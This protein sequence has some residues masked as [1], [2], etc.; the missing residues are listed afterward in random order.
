MS[1][2]KRILEIMGYQVGKTISEQKKIILETYLRKFTNEMADLLINLSSETN[3]IVQ[4]LI[5]RGESLQSLSSFKNLKDKLNS[6]S[7]T[8]GKNFDEQIDIL[9]REIDNAGVGVGKLTDN[10]A[11]V[12]DD[13]LNDSWVNIIRYI[14]NLDNIKDRLNWWSKMGNLD[15][16]DAIRIIRQIDSPGFDA[17]SLTL[18]ELKQL[19]AN[20][21]NLTNIFNSFNVTYPYGKFKTDIVDE[22]KR[23]REKLN[24]GS[25]KENS[26]QSILSRIIPT[27]G[28]ANLIYNLNKWILTYKYEKNP[29]ALSERIQKLSNKITEEI[30][31]V[32][33]EGT[34]DVLMNEFDELTQL[35]FTFKREVG[36]DMEAQLKKLVEEGVVSK[37]IL[38][39][40]EQ[41]KAKGY[42]NLWSVWNKEWDEMMKN[43]EVR[44]TVESFGGRAFED[45]WKAFKEVLS[46]NP[47]TIWGTLIFKSGRENFAKNFKT[48]LQRTGWV[49]LWNDPR[50]PKELVTLRN[51]KGTELK[52]MI[53]GKL[54]SH[55]CFRIV[56]ILS[57]MPV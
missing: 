50:F 42:D 17:K 38:G 21:D 34:I 31:K 24:T 45:E 46:F 35:I 40:F 57:L 15:A 10:E 49:I 29:K 30:N 48:G 44:K 41:Q 37:E 14:D 56:F 47:I 11:K 23:V 28:M 25:K 18:D 51:L 7:K 9:N 55:L 16:S 1:D 22:L 39:F 36:Q 6:W 12:W 53:G 4:D 13:L 54:L 2:V 52:Y 33:S 3:Y 19:R 8:Q 32:G 26:F 20:I 27:E 5:T 43:S